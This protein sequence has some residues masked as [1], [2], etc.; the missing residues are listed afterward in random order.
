MEISAQSLLQESARLLKIIYQLRP[1]EL[2]PNAIILIIR[3]V[4]ERD[5]EKLKTPSSKIDVKY[6]KL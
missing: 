1:V 2:P 4:V 5:F 3:L 6:D